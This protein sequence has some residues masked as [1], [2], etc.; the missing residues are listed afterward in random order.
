V[1]PYLQPCTVLRDGGRRNS[2]EPCRYRNKTTFAITTCASGPQ[3]ALQQATTNNSEGHVCVSACLLQSEQADQLLKCVNNALNDPEVSYSL[4]AFERATST[5]FLKRCVISEGNCSGSSI[6]STTALPSGSDRLSAQ[7]ESHAC[8]AD[9]YFR[10]NWITHG[11]GCKEEQQALAAASRRIHAT[12]PVCVSGI[13]QSVHTKS[14]IAA[15]V[16]SVRVLCGDSALYARVLGM[17]YRI[18]PN[19]FFQVNWC[20]TETLFS[21]IIKAADVSAGDTVL[22]LYCGSGAI[23]LQVSRF[24]SRVVGIDI[25]PASIDDAKANA[26]LN[27]RENVDFYAADLRAKLGKD[28]KVFKAHVLAAK[29]DVLVADPGRSGLS[30]AVNQYISE[31]RQIRRVVYVSCNSETMCRDIRSI[32]STGRWRCTSVVGLDMFPQTDHLEQIAVLERYGVPMYH[33]R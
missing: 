10:V 28:R 25:V 13:V 33:D 18:S 6:P 20:Q 3:L 22:D 14:S 27:E 29:A 21:E 11:L 19:A 8:T 4:T 15:P 16:D 9:K 2:P 32:C 17:K 23:A 30:E 1:Q 24:C 7:L 12:A 26:E 31:D 5:G